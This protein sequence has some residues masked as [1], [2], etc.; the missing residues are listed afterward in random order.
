M[1]KI[2]LLSFLAPILTGLSVWFIQRKLEEK[3]VV[4]LLRSEYSRYSG[5]WFG[6]HLSKIGKNNK[7]V[8]SRHSYMI[9]V[10]KRGDIQGEFLDY[11]SEDEPWKYIIHGK[12]IPGGLI[13][14]SMND[15][16]PDLYSI[17]IFFNPL[18]TNKLEGV[19]VSYDYQN[20][21]FVSPIVLT[22]KKLTIAEFENE[23]SNLR[24]KYYDSIEDL[25]DY[26]LNE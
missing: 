17:Q 19:L 22:R 24:S 8:V 6:I 11:L 23:L 10:S 14:N 2:I 12:V 4:K 15:L 7:R 3:K 25:T 26:N 16:R 5:K 20:N 1:L 9:N 13:L 18:S 21:P